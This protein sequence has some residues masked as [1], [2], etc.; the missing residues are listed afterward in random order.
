MCFYR[1]LSFLKDSYNAFKL[2]RRVKMKIFISSNFKVCFE[3]L[4]NITNDSFSHT[5][6]HIFPGVGSLCQHWILISIGHH[7]LKGLC[8]V[9]EPEILLRRVKNMDSALHYS[10]P[11]QWRSLLWWWTLA[12]RPPADF[13]CSAGTPGYKPAW[14]CPYEDLGRTISF[15][16][17]F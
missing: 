9:S 17:N 10:L 15:L 2:L 3:M 16:H 1:T 13:S 12:G 6:I 14:K 4:V 7:F 11:G 5:T 8:E